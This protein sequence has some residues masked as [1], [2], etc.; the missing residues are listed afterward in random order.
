MKDA[1]RPRNEDP[2]QR[3]LD[4]QHWHEEDEKDRAQRKKFWIH[5]VFDILLVAGTV[6]ATRHFLTQQFQEEKTKLQS[7]ITWLETQMATK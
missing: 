2:T 7:K 6:F 4:R 1:V 5:I 3:S